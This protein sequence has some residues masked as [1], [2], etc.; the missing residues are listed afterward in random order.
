[1]QDFSS[2]ADAL[3]PTSPKGYINADFGVALKHST[4]CVHRQLFF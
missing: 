2:S 3:G 1:M 4:I